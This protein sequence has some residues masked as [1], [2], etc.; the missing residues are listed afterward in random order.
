MANTL[1]T[2]DLAANLLKHIGCQNLRRL[3]QFFPNSAELFKQNA[4]SLAQITGLSSDNA[5]RLCQQ[6]PS[7]LKQA[8][9]ELEIMHKNN[10][11]AVYYTDPAFPQRML[12]CPDSPNV[13]FYKGQPE[14]NNRRFIAIVGTRNATEY[15]KNCC[16]KLVQELA[17]QQPALCIVSGLAYG[18]DGVAHQK[19]LDLQIPTLA[20]M[21]GGFNHFYPQVHKNMALEI[22]R[23]PQS[24][25]I[26]ENTFDILPEAFN[27][28]KR[29]RIIAALS[30]ATIVVESA[31]KGGSLITANLAHS[32]N[33]D[34]FCIPGRIDDYSSRGCLQLIKQNKAV[35]IENAEDVAYNMGWHCREKE[36]AHQLSLFTELHGDEERIYNLLLKE[37]KLHFDQL[38]NLLIDV[39]LQSVLLEMECKELIKCLP[40][41]FYIPL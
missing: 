39:N 21:A 20:V 3:L 33:R 23:R 10:I 12:D 36:T 5:L 11:S 8:E 28:V 37:K 2:T 26:T 34:V 19:C 30:D 25:L 35:L 7:V 18:I 1:S 27:F 4:G 6:F 14:F 31:N 17:Q 24:G 41:N 22:E 38:S 16:K 15:G 40:G 9:T 13:L 32:Y 29:N